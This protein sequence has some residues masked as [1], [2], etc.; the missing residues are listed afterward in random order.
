MCLGSSGST[1][2]AQA[3][4]FQFDA[5]GAV[6]EAVEDGVG[7][8]GIAHGLVPAFDRHLA[9]DDQRATIVAVV[10]DL[11]QV[12]ALLGGQRFGPPVVQ[13]QQ[14]DAGGAGGPAR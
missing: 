10:D 3:F 5:V 7:Q 8:R 14:I 11:Q 13:D 2:L 12:A 1:L 9:G 6:D 4:A